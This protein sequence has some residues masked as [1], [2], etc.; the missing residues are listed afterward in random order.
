MCMM[1]HAASVANTYHACSDD[2]VDGGGAAM[3]QDVARS[4]GVGLSRKARALAMDILTGVAC[5]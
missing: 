2:G 5:N 1:R 4:G 3:E